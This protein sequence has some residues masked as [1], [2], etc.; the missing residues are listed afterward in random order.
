MAAWFL[1][2]LKMPIGNVLAADSLPTKFCEEVT[3][4]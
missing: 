4:R 1:L 2:K 3:I